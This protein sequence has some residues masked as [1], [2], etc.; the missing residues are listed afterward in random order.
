VTEPRSVFFDLQDRL[1]HAIVHRLRWRELRAVQEDTVRAVRQGK[2]CIVLAPTAGGKTEASMFGVLDGLLRAGSTGLGALY[3]SPLR[4]LLNNQEPRLNQLTEMVGLSAFKWHGDVS[5]SDK[6][7]FVQSPRSLLMTTPESLEVI[8]M[9]QRYDQQALLKNLRYVIIDEIHGFAG[10]D[11]GDHLLTLLERLT[12]YS[13][14]DFQRIG[15]SATVGNPGDLVSWIQGSSQRGGEV[16]DPGGPRQ[17]KIIDILP[18][19]EGFDPARTAA[20]LA[21]GKKSLLFADSRAKVEQMKDGL[22]RS[23]IRAFP[24]HGSLSRSLREESEEAFRSGSN[25]SIVCTSTMELGLDV[26]DLDIVLQL[27]APSTVSAFLQR[28]GR[29]G[30]RPGTV[31]RMTFMCDK[32]ENFLIACS[33]VSLAIKRWVEPVELIEASYPVFVHQI[34]AAILRQGGATEKTLLKGFGEPYCFSKITL[35]ER[36]EIL[37]E[38]SEQEVI[39]SVDSLYQLGPEGERRFGRSNFMSLYSVFDTPS[40]LTVRTESHRKIG[41]L[42]SWFVQSQDD[43]L[44][45]LLGG[46][47]WQAVRVDWERRVLVVKPASKGAVPTWMGQPTLLSSEICQE[48]KALLL[49][50]EDPVFLGDRGLRYLRGLRSEWGGVVSQSPFVYEEVGQ[51]WV[52]IHTFAGGKINNVIARF[53]QFRTGRKVQV[54]NFR[55]KTERPESGPYWGE[56]EESLETLAQQDLAPEA[57]TGMLSGLKKSR[58]SKFQE[59]LPSKLESK[60]LCQRLFDVQGAQTRS[61]DQLATRE[62]RGPL[63][64]P[65]RDRLPSPAVPSMDGPVVNEP[66]PSEER[67]FPDDPFLDQ[68]ARLAREHPIVT[69]WV[70]VESQQQKQLLGERLCLAGVDW[71]NFRFVTPFEVALEVAAPELLSRGIRPQAEGLGPLLVLQLMKELPESL[72]QFFGPLLD[73]P[74][75]A[76]ALW[77]TLWEL[78]MAGIHSDRLPQSTDKQREIR[79]LL[80]AYEAELERQKEGDRSKVL[81]VAMALKGQ[82][83]VNCEDLILEMPTALWAPLER[84]Y[85]DTLAGQRVQSRCPI[86]NVPRRLEFLCPHRD[87]MERPHTRD[88]HNL[89]GLREVGKASNVIKDGSLQ[90]FQA[91]RREGEVLEILRRVF[92]QE[93]PLDQV[94]VCAANAEDQFLLR[95]KVTQ[96]DLPLTLSNGLPVLASRCGK[97]LLGFLQWIESDFSAYELRRVFLTGRVN[98]GLSPG[99]AA[100]LLERSAA[101]WGRDSYERHLLPLQ[102]RFQAQEQDDKAERTGVLSDWIATRLA[103]IPSEEGDGKVRFGDFVAAVSGFLESLRCGDDP[104]EQSALKALQ[105]SLSELEK[106]WILRLGLSASINQIRQRLGRLRCGASRAAPGHL[107]LSTL[108]ELGESGRPNTFILGLEEG[109]LPTGATEDPVLTDLERRELHPGLALS[110]DRATEAA[111]L[112]MQRFETLSGHVTLSFSVRD[113]L[114]GEETL[115]SWLFFKVVQRLHARLHRR[116]DLTAFIGEAVSLVPSESVS[117]INESEWWLSR[118]RAQ[119]PSASHVTRRGF[120][121]L[122]RGYEAQQ[123]RSSQRFTS[124]DGLVTTLAGRLD[125]R[126]NGEATSVSALQDLATCAFRTYL[127]RGLK[128]KPPEIEKREPGVWLNAAQRGTLLHDVFADYHRFLRINGRGPNCETDHSVLMQAMHQRLSVLS[129]ER[130]APSQVVEEQMHESLSQV[131]LNFLHLESSD[132]Q[133]RPLG[134]EVGFG[135]P[136][137]EDEVFA[138]QH[139]VELDLGGGMRF[140][141]RG[142]IDRIDRIDGEIEVIDYKTGVSLSR[143]RGVRYDGGRLIQ[144]A[145]YALVAEQL[146]GE[147]VSSTSYY[148]PT[149]QAERAWLRFP[150]PQASDVRDVLSHLLTPLATGSF[151]PT[152]NSADCRYCDFQAA[153]LSRSDSEV[154]QMLENE[155]NSGLDWRR[156]LDQI[157]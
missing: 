105:T 66:L 17:K 41:E 83:P 92:L 7:K 155:T 123:Q 143:K 139:P 26:G 30:R 122:C 67:T 129:L 23:G 133:R 79:A 52:S 22:E 126:L 135:L 36:K 57:L 98:P 62:V 130:P 44:C 88:L 47:A 96:L 20:V 85:L 118:L 146:I 3:L 42:E 34:L 71:L 65:D 127:R 8:L 113:K 50:Q 6:A 29:T 68:L 56:L 99:D 74:G 154:S 134:L 12:A 137:L 13:D 97:A 120:P 124:Y 102:Q 106:P 70:F 147:P 59:C 49:S 116:E 48:V 103:T 90:V 73:Q 94:E 25:C 87:P 33:L 112:L 82:S 140:R 131:L 144:H 104:F 19:P 109:A 91:G 84:K 35:D 9:T 108:R 27:G 1:Q 121:W 149:S 4:A 58:L 63:A 75:M 69:K 114:S 145:L 86:S 45:F 76:E 125:P 111:F 32:P 43:S 40:I 157:T 24:H 81:S 14:H 80:E 95:D 93:L 72:A 5:A 51:N 46:K 38:L 132:P 119:G 136:D 107:H 148:F 142:R 60:F 2:N 54:H 117:A 152:A 16:V 153:C 31:A 101:T 18:L 61:R 28:L 150:R 64:P 115:P 141:L 128:V 110:R 89:R 53:H 39:L 55:I 37:R 21:R 78:R 15:L 156:R 10:D 11:R 138:T 151:L 77:R 100:R